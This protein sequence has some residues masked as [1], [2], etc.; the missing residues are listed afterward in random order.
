M[1]GQP[2]IPLLSR[3]N[4]VETVMTGE[5]SA[6]TPGT[7]G[8]DPQPVWTVGTTAALAVALLLGVVAPLAVAAG[9]HGPAPDRS[10]IMAD[11]LPPAV[12]ARVMISRPGRAPHPVT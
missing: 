3:Y 2:G 1:A 8:P 5:G 7:A 11:G 12:P 6:S 4:P 9:H 10:A